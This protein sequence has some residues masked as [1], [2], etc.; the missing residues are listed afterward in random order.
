MKDMFEALIDERK[1]ESFE[2]Q[3][4]Y[5]RPSYHSAERIAVGVAS[6]CEN[7]IEV[8]FLTSASAMDSMARLLGDDG[9]EQYHFAASECRRAI[10]QST[11]LDMLQMPTDALVAGEKMAAFT[12]DRVGLISRLLET[13]SC[14][15]R[16]SSPR[17]NEVASGSAAVNL[18]K[19]VFDH[20]SR[21][22]PAL[23]NEIFNKS[24]DIDGATV[25]LPI[26]GRKVFGAPV[27]FVN[28]SQTMR[29]ESWV[30]KFHW[31]KTI[32]VPSPKLYLITGK[33]EENETSKVEGKIRE[34]RAI[35]KS[36]A[37]ELAVASTTDELAH[38]VVRD[39]AA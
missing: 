11:T 8:R 26:Y 3:L 23:A 5:L 2:Y 21:L 33:D 32:L 25:E 10:G 17:T 9:V 35:A 30:A 34:L 22:N 24:V 6:T 18:V 12:P 37:V 15:V 13:S 7:R 28:S 31:L 27:S 38:M 14:L 29:A 4:L 39:E 36:A 1:F 19:S 20:V 16:Q